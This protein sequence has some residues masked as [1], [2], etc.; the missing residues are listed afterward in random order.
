MGK[1]GEKTEIALGETQVIME[2]KKALV[3]AGVNIAT[4]E[5]CVAGKTEGAKRS[6]HIQLVKNLPCGSS[7]GELAKIFGK[8]G[9][10]WTKLFFL[11]QKL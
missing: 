1:H 2:T 10:V 7:E 3:N 8:Y 11:Q 5:E 6:S 9:R 4:L